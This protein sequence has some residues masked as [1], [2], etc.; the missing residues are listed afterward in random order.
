MR[1]LVGRLPSGG[2]TFVLVN[3]TSAPQ[4][5]PLTEPTGTITLN[6]YAYTD[7]STPTVD[8]DG[9]PVPVGKLTADFTGGHSLTMRQ[10]ARS[11]CSPPLPDPA[12]RACTRR[13]VGRSSAHHWPVTRSHRSVATSSSPKS[14]H[15]ASNWRV[16]GASSPSESGIARR[17]L[18]QAD[19]TTRLR[20]AK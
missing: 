19:S 12:G 8:A 17:A 4:S 5:V 16:A 15:S 3:R 6:K 10:P 14:S 1:V 2:W 20:A 18:W 7:R 11:R 13:A 9:F